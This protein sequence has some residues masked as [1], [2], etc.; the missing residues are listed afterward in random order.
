MISWK[1]TRVPLYLGHLEASRMAH[2]LDGP[3][4]EYGGRDVFMSD[5]LA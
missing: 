5:A 4:V 1:T 2:R 3:I